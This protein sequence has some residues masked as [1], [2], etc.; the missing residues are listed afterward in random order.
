[1]DP[2]GNFK[3]TIVMHYKCNLLQY[4]HAHEREVYIQIQS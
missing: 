1:M 2:K 3:I 4:I